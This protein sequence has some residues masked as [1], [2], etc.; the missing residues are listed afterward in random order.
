MG[1]IPENV[2]MIYAPRD[3]QE[4]EIVLRLVEESRRYAIGDG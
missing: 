3:E 1:Y 2:V 4:M